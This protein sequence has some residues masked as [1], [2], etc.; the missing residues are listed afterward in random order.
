MGL[1]FYW[2]GFLKV[3]NL[4]VLAPLSRLAFIIGAWLVFEGISKSSEFVGVGFAGEPGLYYWRL[5][6]IEMDF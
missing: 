3:L 5:A 4:W 1:G 6:F 2:N